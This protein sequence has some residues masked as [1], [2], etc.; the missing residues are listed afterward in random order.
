VLFALNANDEPFRPGSVFIVS[1]GAAIV[2]NYHVIEGAHSIAAKTSAGDTFRLT[3]VLHIDEKKDIAVLRMQHRG[4]AARK[5][6]P[7]AAVHFT[8]LSWTFTAQPRRHTPHH[9]NS[10]N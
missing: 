10:E 8:P 9:L 3:S 4:I 2:T 7:F 1:G 6:I 5:A